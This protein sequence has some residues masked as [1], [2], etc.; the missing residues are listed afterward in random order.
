MGAKMG[1]I[2]CQ[3]ECTLLPEELEKL[4]KWAEKESLLARDGNS[5]VPHAVLMLTLNA[6][7]YAKM[8]G[9]PEDEDISEDDSFVEEWR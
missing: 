5:T 4:E 1:V 7:H 6:I 3:S 8:S 9:F 2:K